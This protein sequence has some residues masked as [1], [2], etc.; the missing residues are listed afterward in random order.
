MDR[1]SYHSREPFDPHHYDYEDYDYPPPRRLPS[2]NS[3]E[4]FRRGHDD[5]RNDYDMYHKDHRDDYYGRPPPYGY[6]EFDDRYPPE[7]FTGPIDEA[8]K[9]ILLD[10]SDELISPIPF[11]P[12]KINPLLAHEKN[13]GDRIIFIKSQSYMLDHIVKS[14][15]R[16]SGKVERFAKLSYNE[17][18]AEMSTYTMTIHAYKMFKIFRTFNPKFEAYTIEILSEEQIRQ[19][20]QKREQEEKV[21]FKP[22]KCLVVHGIE[23][24]EEK[25]KKYLQSFS[26]SKY[27]IIPEEKVLVT[28]HRNLASVNDFMDAFLNGKSGLPPLTVKEEINKDKLKSDVLRI[29]KDKL[30]EACVNDCT[31]CLIPDLYVYAL[32]RERMNIIRSRRP[33]GDSNRLLNFYS[34]DLAIGFYVSP[35]LQSAVILRDKVKTETRKRKTEMIKTDNAGYQRKVVNQMREEIATSF[36]KLKQPEILNNSSRLTPIHKIDEGEKRNY[37]RAYAISRLHPI[38]V[39]RDSGLNIRQSQ[40]P[41]N[42]KPQSRRRLTSSVPRPIHVQSIIGK[43][44]YFEKSTIQGWGLFS[45]EPINTDSLICEYTGELVRS[46]VADMREQRYDKAGLQMYLFRIEEYIIDA[47]MCGGLARFLNHSCNPNCRSNIVT[48]GK[49]KTI[50]F[51]AI[52]NIKAHEEITFNYQMEP[53]KDESKWERC[54]CNAKQCTGY[55]NRP[56]NTKQHAFRADDVF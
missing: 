53:E 54:F 16:L 23:L 25:I 17:V 32:R 46:A 44:L 34:P 11:E 9:P 56:T 35:K 21:I 12:P 36:E 45:L 41:T 22:E 30:L 13:E 6:R 7:N 18:F 26:I 19:K 31:E 50:S 10:L 47:T 28:Y 39:A 15:L 52:R 4:D 1:R 49:T 14:R 51:Y 8:S 55:L 42:V 40:F 38:I 29:I 5:Y 3:Y 37:L 43:R 33:Y 20:T 48:Y 27:E 24:P 2:R